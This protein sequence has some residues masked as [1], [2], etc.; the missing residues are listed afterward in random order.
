MGVEDHFGIAIQTTEA[1][2]VRTVGDLVAL[3]QSRIEAAHVAICPTLASSSKLRTCVREIAADDALRIR[4]G[5]RIVEV[6]T[7]CRSSRRSLG[8]GE[9]TSRQPAVL[10]CN[11]I[12]DPDDASTGPE[13]RD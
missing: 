5:T 12:P 11:V 13:R 8:R 3:I 7:R 2:R 1:E 4:S 9:L 10:A 6:L